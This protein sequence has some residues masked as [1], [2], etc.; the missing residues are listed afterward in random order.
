MPELPEVETVRKGLELAVVGQKITKVKV[1][2]AKTIEKNSPDEFSQQL[3]GQT[4]KAIKRKAKYLFLE[5]QS[6]LVISV[7]LKMSGAFIVSQAEQELPNHVHVIFDLSN[8]KELRFRD[9]RA[10]GRMS[11]YKNIEEAQQIGS[12]PNLAPEPI[13]EHFNEKD[14]ANQLSKFSSPIKAI[15][16]DQTKAVSGVGN[17]YADESLFLGGIR[18]QVPANQLNKKQVHALYNAIK[19]VIGAAIEAGGTSVRDYV[20]ANGDLGNFALQLNVYGQKKKNCKVCATP[21]EY[22][23]LAQRGTHYCPTCQKG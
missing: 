14:F 16:L 7:H 8:K 13:E 12:I 17:I 2:R 3:T 10:F 5:M 1:N 20:N 18:P 6:N 19:Q 22:I 15:L 11:L 21:I 4:F 23:R 9:L